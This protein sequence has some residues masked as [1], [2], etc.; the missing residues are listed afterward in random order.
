MRTSSKLPYDF[1]LLQ[2]GKVSESL[3]RRRF[4]DVQKRLL[5]ESIDEVATRKLAGK[6]F[7][8]IAPAFKSHDAAA[9]AGLRRVTE[10]LAKRKL[11][12]PQKVHLP[13]IV[14]GSYTL[15]FTPPY[16]AFGGVS[17]GQ[18]TDVTGNPTIASTGVDSLGQMTC[19][20]DTNF[21]KPSGGTASNLMGV[22]FKPK[23]TNAIARIS[24]S[25]E[26]SFSWYVNSIQNKPAFSRAQGL[27]QLFQFDDTFVQPSL[28]RGAFIGWNEEAVN[29][30]DFDFVSET[31]PTWF[32]EA[33]VSS[34]HF[35]FVVISLTCTASGQGWPGSLA[36]AK[37]VVTVPSITVTISNTPVNTSL[38][39][40]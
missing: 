39:Q 24:F 9:I 31:G 1:E 10:R 22:H 34:A 28:R 36:G 16:T 23:F 30:L 40:L 18:I 35:Y 27:I 19:S 15:Q 32:L 29:S 33:P 4:A 25:S 6:Y 38:A 8:E 5:A 7:G 12:V 21:D 11:A 14:F 20:V 17:A 3:A 2:G 13:P 26:F 37:A